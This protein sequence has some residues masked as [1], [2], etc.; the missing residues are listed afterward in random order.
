MPYLCV[1]KTEMYVCD[2][3]LTIYFFFESNRTFKNYG[4]FI[5]N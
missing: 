1:I 4:Q 2:S 3:F 5:K